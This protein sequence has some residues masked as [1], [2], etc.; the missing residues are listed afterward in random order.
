MFQNLAKYSVFLTPKFYH[1]GNL[2]GFEKMADKYT[3]VVLSES[4]V[5]KAV[6][7]AEFNFKSV[8]V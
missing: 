7:F 4:F 3:I 2:H 1:P 8:L 6:Y 5:I